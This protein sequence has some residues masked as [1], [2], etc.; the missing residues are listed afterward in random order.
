MITHDTKTEVTREGVSAGEST[1]HIKANA[2]AFNILSA[3][4]YTDRIKAIVRELSTNAWDAHVMANNVD[5]P[6]DIHLPTYLD[7]TFYVKDYGTGLSDVQIR[8]ETVDGEFVPGIYQ[9]FFDS[10]KQNSNDVIGCLGLGSKSPFSYSA[11]FIV[12]SRYQGMKRTYNM[13]KNESGLPSVALMDEQPM[14]ADEHTGLTVMLSVKSADIDKFTNAAKKALMYF[15]PLPT[16][17]G[18]TSFKPFDLRHTV[19]GT[20]WRIRESDYYAHM[21]GPY[22]V[23]GFVAYPVDSNI[24]SEHQQLSGCAAALCEVDL[25]L[26]VAIGGVE[27]APSREALDYDARTIVN[28]ACSLEQAAGEMRKSFQ[29]AIDKCTTQW[30]AAILLDTY[31]HSKSDKFSK[32]FTHMHKAEPFQFQGS[33][34]TQT[35]RFPIAAMKNVQIVLATLA[36][37]RRGKGDK[38][39]TSNSWQA[40]G[41]ASM[42]EFLVQG[43]LHVVTDSKSTRLKSPAIKAWLNGKGQVNTHKCRAL[44]VRPLDKSGNMDGV[45]AVIAAIG[46]PDVITMDSIPQ[47]ARARSGY[48]SVKRDKQS[49][50]VWQGFPESKTRWG[51]DD[52]H[53]KFSRLT[54]QAEDVDLADGGIYIDLDRFSAMD[55]KGNEFLYMDDFIVAA[56]KLGLLD[57]GDI[58]GMTKKELVAAQQEGEWINLIDEVTSNFEMAN[59]NGEMF[60]KGI[61]SSVNKLLDAAFVTNVMGRWS[62]FSTLGD[63]ALRTFVEDHKTLEQSACDHP[64]PLL[65]TVMGVCGIKYDAQAEIDKRVGEY[66]A[67]MS[68]YPLFGMMHWERVTTNRSAFIEYVSSVGC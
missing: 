26:Y 32:V 22:V 31:Q 15:N 5:T 65:D 33:D 19:T 64:V 34:L 6:F 50:L 57:S 41:F 25:D 54:W 45:N 23:Q 9:T 35:I 63:C 29:A 52:V 43:G 30:E 10:N 8:G 17:V 36:S 46:C 16:F 58:I 1:F 28:L 59:E 67:M 38:L 13:F 48:T 47:V 49:R 60:N 44:I 14:A 2:K 66:K 4:L 61:L 39:D 55:K 68:K 62:V 51:A 24:I 42:Y 40:G 20:N 3:A 7:Q 21:S 11:T 27:V 56:M 18:Q 53:R 37:G 12:E